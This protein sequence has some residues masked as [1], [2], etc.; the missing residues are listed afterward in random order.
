VRQVLL[1]A[2]FGLVVTLFGTPVAIRLLV[3]RNYGQLIRDDGPTSHH[4]KRGTPTMGG[5]VIIFGTLLGYFGAH[6]ITWR[7]TTASGLLVLYLMTG[8]GVVGFLDDYIKVSKQRSLGLLAG[9]KLGGQMV[10][11]V[12]FA[13]AAIHFPD[14]LGNTPASTHI[15]FIRDTGLVLG[16]VLFVAWAYVMIA[17]TSNGVNLT[18]G[19]DGLATGTSVMV[20]ASY[21]L[22]GIW[23]FGNNCGLADAPKACYEVR[24][25]LDLAV[26][27]AAIMGACF[28]FLW[29]NAS[30]AKIFMGDTGSLALGGGLAG[31]AITSRTELLLVLLG[32][33]F[34]L[35]TLSVIVQVGFFKL[36]GKRVFRMAPLQH[37]FE[38][39][40]WGEVTIVIRFWIIA[41]LLVALG[42]GVFYAEWV[43]GA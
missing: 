31:I 34:A 35:I 2:S 22:I 13:I 23:Q 16:T 28:G 32:G 24:D 17:G 11:A 39:V 25:P 27:A 38:L 19:L 43:A 5:A 1:A 42:L 20:F 4:T 8:L 29:W 18:D 15:S 40:G 9:A 33:L 37:H 7:D 41:G 3:R 21:V 12:S 14:A 30:P 26:V 10:V 36:T 6:L